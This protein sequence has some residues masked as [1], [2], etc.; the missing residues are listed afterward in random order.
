MLWFYDSQ[1]HHIF[2][3]RYLSI[4]YLL[5]GVNLLADSWLAL[6]AGKSG[7]YR[8]SRTLETYFGTQ[9]IGDVGGPEN[10]H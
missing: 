1:C 10:K 9:F 7:V 6:L 5:H 3:A 4:K 2:S 8:V